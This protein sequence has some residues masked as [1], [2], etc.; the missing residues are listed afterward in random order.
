[1]ATKIE[2]QHVEMNISTMTDAEIASTIGAIQKVGATSSLLQNPAIAASAAALAKKGSALT[3]AG[4]VVTIDEKQ[5]KLDIAARAVAR[6][7][8]EGELANLRTLVSTN[9]TSPADIAG[10]G[11][12][13]LVRLTQTRTVPPAPA[14]IITRLGK[15]H[16]RA[17]VAVVENAGAHGSYV[18]EATADPVSVTS[19][20]TSLPGTGKQRVLTGATGAKLWVRFAQV[21]YGLQSDWSTSVLVTLP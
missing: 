17:R 21:R 1:M 16:G 5:L 19:A 11:M 3:A 15:V 18:A 4:L 8:V 9:A 14:E 6:T 13:P 12:I 20:W 2:H 10:M 7:S